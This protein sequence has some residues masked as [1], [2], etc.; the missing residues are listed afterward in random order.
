[1]KF[2]LQSQVIDPILW[3]ALK[4][5]YKKSSATTDSCRLGTFRKRDHD[6]HPDDDALLKGERIMK[7]QKMSR[8]SKS[9]RGSSSKQP[10]K[11][12]NTTTSEQPQQHDYDPWLKFQKLLKT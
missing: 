5:K 6:D 9:V 12:S 10:A 3:N 4:A 8:R 7:R 2:D 11:G 1:M